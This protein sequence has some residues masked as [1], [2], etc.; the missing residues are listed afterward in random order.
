[1]SESTALVLVSK[2]ENKNE[3]KVRPAAMAFYHGDGLI[4]SYNYAKAFAG[5]GGRVATLP[6]IWDVRLARL[7]DRLEMEPGMMRPGAPWDTYYTTTSAEYMG[8]SRGGNLIIIVA[9]GIGPMRDLDWMV[10]AYRHEFRDE[11]RDIRGGRIDREEFLR[12]ESGDYGEVGIVDLRSYLSRYRFPFISHISYEQALTD[13]LLHARMGARWSE[14][15]SAQ[16]AVSDQWHE[17]NKEGEAKRLARWRVTNPRPANIFD[18]SDNSNFNYRSMFERP[19]YLKAVTQDGKYAVGH[20][21]STGGVQTAQ[22]TGNDADYTGVVSDIGLH[23]W[24]DGTRFVGI[25]SD[26]DLS[27]IHSGPSNLRAAICKHWKRIGVPAGHKDPLPRE[28]GFYR[29]DGKSDF[30]VRQDDDSKVLQA[31]DPEFKV[32]DATEIG[33]GEFVTEIEGY[34]GFFR[35]CP[36]DVRKIA[37]PEANAFNFVSDPEIV[38]NDGNPTHH[39]VS[40]VFFRANVDTTL[41]IPTE[42]EIL[43]DFAL[44]MKLTLDEI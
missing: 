28:R 7:K 38:W 34:H 8:R 16:K 9:H 25:R 13:P 44:T 11:S 42:A 22:Y 32:L 4:P 39:K 35:Y 29:L 30:T 19:Q 2:N 15:V 40:V 37:P 33:R 1:M 21:L 3:R 23:S 27:N 36:K 20:L 10:K 5:E 24:Y 43:R 41:R 26:S 17:A 31:S 12:L 6:D 14:Y 18:V